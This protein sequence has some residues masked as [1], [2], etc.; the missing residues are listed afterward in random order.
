MI[1]VYD[2]IKRPI[3]TEKAMAAKESMNQITFEVDRRANK[4]II[5]K[6]V[7]KFFDVKV[8]DVKTMNFNGKKK[9]FGQKNGKRQD[10]KKA[11]IILE[12][13]QNLEFV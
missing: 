2:V 5:K 10:W 9:R 12:E 8:T 4:D 13:G 7:E 6:A 1:T 3:I 11:I